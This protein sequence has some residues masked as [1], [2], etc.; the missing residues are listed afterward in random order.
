MRDR[1][2][3]HAEI[4]ARRHAALYSQTS[5]TKKRGRPC[6]KKQAT[7]EQILF[8]QLCRDGMDPRLARDIAYNN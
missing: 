6:N 5:R 7:P 3:K 2:R 4:N 1:E 8:A